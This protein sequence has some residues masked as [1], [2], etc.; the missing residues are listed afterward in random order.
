MIRKKVALTVMVFMVCAG[1]LA[2]AIEKEVEL[3]LGT[4]VEAPTADKLILVLPSGQRLELEGVT[5][6]QAGFPRCVL[7][8]PGGGILA[9]GIQAKFVQPSTEKL[10]ILPSAIRLVA[11]GD[12]L[13]WVR[14]GAPVPPGS[15][16]R[17]N[18]EVVWLPAKLQFLKAGSQVIPAPNPKN[19]S[20]VPR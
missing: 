8:G 16:I 20:E 18:E 1:M 14:Q 10:V 5:T 19:P 2:A 13:M 9:Q 6:I 12:D 7:R 17:V 3:P 15:Y 4:Q 11:V